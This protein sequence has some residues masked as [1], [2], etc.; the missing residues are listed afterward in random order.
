MDFVFYRVELCVVLKAISHTF[1]VCFGKS[2]TGNMN[3]KTVFQT[4]IPQKLRHST[5]FDVWHRIGGIPVFIIHTAGIA[6]PITH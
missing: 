1:D 3:W 2:C 6:L 5:R 4:G